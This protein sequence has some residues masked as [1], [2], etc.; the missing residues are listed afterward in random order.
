MLYNRKAYGRS[1][2][3]YYFFDYIGGIQNGQSL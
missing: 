2:N 3:F 1:M